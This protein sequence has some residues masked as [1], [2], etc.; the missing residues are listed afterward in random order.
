MAI[1]PS[2][3][4]QHLDSQR[5][6]INQTRENSTRFAESFATLNT[7][8]WGEFA[9][10]A[11]FEFGL[12]FIQMPHVSY[13]W[14]LDGDTLVDTRFPRA[15]GGVYRWKQDK[16]GFYVGAW[17]CLTVDTQSPYIDIGSEPQPNYTMTH[18]FTFAGKAIKDLPAHLAAQ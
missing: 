1:G 10:D 2:N 3:P 14:S 4:L 16:R 8:G 11:C 12:T 18:Y 6:L 5:A 17:M 15:G 9:F 13:S 7:T